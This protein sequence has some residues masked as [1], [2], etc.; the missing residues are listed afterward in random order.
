MRERVSRVALAHQEVK[1]DGYA[2]LVSVAG[3][4]REVKA[5]H[6]VGR[7]DGGAEVVVI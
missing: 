7:V 5:N 4:G 6:Q 1:D 3:G 2:H